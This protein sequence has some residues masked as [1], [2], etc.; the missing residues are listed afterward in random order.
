MRFQSGNH[1]LV[2]KP[3]D[4]NYPDWQQ[5]VPREMVASVTVAGRPPGRRDRLAALV[6]RPQQLGDPAARQARPCMVLESRLG[7][8]VPPPPSRCRW[9][10]PA[11]PNRWRSTRPIWPTRWK[12]PRCCGSPMP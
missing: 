2:S 7:R 10:P 5:V 8:R 4:G 9:K 3:I 11:N 1:T 12:S 6:A